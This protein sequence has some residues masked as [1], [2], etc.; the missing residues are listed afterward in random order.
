MP[1]PRSRL[2]AAREQVLG[3]TR[4]KF[5][6]LVERES[7][8]PCD[9][10]M[11]WRWEHSGV[12]P[13][14]ARLRAVATITGLTVAE[15]GWSD[16][17][18]DPTVSGL[19]VLDHLAQAQ[20]SLRRA[21]DEVGARPV[22]PVALAQVRL[23]D[24]L[25]RDARGS[26]LRPLLRE[27]AQ[28]SQFTAWLHSDLAIPAGAAE[29]YLRAGEQA[30][31]ACDADMVS[32]VLSMRS[33]LAW[34]ERQP[35]LAVGLAD[36]ALAVPGT[37]PATRSQA[38]QQLAR[39]LAMLGESDRVDRLLDEAEGAA[40]AAVE[41]AETVPPWLYFH[42]P[43]RARVQRAV[44]YTEAGR[45]REA[46]EVLSEAIGRTRPEEVRDRGWN[47]GRLAVAW[48]MAGE[49]D[50]AIDAGRQAAAIT[51]IAPSA[52]TAGELRR[53]ARMLAHAGADRE[54]AELAELARA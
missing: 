50:A 10:R 19:G 44:A 32:T 26:Q 18:A 43:A 27:A 2:R 6:A 33:H 34:G 20:A 7:G 47:Y 46:A 40:H 14:P 25:A 12:K 15:L 13:R 52:H 53:A 45:G 23:V 35:G 5:A 29:W 1:K 21:E 3:L 8:E 16:G 9:E 24:T 4:A 54:A 49:A 17:V 42:N 11:V 41:R 38:A 37:H 51:S 22:L 30:R 31:E 28:W 36:G 39:G 48:A